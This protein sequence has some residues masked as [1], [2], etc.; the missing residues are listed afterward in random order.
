MNHCLSTKLGGWGRYPVAATELYRPEKIAELGAVLKKEQHLIGRGRGLSYGD[1]ALCGGGATIDFGRLNR[2]IRFDR[3]RGIIDCE[4]GVRLEEILEI[5]VPHGWFLPVT[6]GTRFPTIGGCLACDVHGKNHHRDGCLSNHVRAFHLL[7]ADGQA[8]SCSRAE[9]ADLFRATAGG[10]GLTGLIQ[11]VS[12]QLIPIESAYIRQL[13]I[14][15]AN[16]EQT[17]AALTEANH[18]SRYTVAWLDTVCGGAGLG[19]GIV[20]AGDTAAREELPKELQASPF[21][22]PQKHPWTVPFNLPSWV[23]NRTA[24]KSFNFCYYHKTAAGRQE[25]ILDYNT[26]FYPL[27]ALLQWNRLYGKRGFLQYQCVL[28]LAGCEES[29]REILAQTAAIGGGSF[30]SV[31]KIM[32]DQ[33]GLLSFPMK[34]VTL[35]MDFANRPDIDRLMSGL[36]RIVLQHGGRLYLAKDARLNRETFAAMQPNLERWLKIKREVDPDGRF[37]SSLSRRIGLT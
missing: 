20:Y 24:I 21:T 23:L 18:A 22:V 30:L 16:L 31:L 1:A 26:F 25:S 15:T 36:D 11:T 33:E 4:A 14:K 28:P 19:R 10:M 3:Q 27:D 17:L 29:L 34:G 13:A 2:F 6:P 5:T 32:G 37:N 12:L 9:N 35:A 8:V 7:L